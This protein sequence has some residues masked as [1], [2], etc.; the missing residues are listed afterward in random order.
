MKKHTLRYYLCILYSL[1]W[2]PN[3]VLAGSHF[4]S[5]TEIQQAIDEANQAYQNYQDCISNCES[6]REQYI[7]NLRGLIYDQEASHVM[8]DEQFDAISAIPR[9][10]TGKAIMIG[11]SEGNDNI[12]F[13][14]NNVTI[15]APRSRFLWDSM[16]SGQ[17]RLDIGSNRGESDIYQSD[18]LTNNFIELDLPE[19]GRK[20]YLRLSTQVD[21]EWQYNDYMYTAYHRQ[22]D[23]LALHSYTRDDTVPYG[24]NVVFND[25]VHGFNVGLKIINSQGKGRLFF[26]IQLDKPI[27]NLVF[28][29]SATK[30]ADI[31]GIRF[32]SNNEKILFLLGTK[33]GAVAAEGE[34]WHYSSA[35]DKEGI[36]KVAFKI[37]GNG[38]AQVFINDTFAQK[39]TLTEQQK[40]ATYTELQIN[41]IDSIY[42]GLYSLKIENTQ[43]STNCTDS[44]NT[45]SNSNCQPQTLDA[46]ALFELSKSYEQQGLYAKALETIQQALKL[47][48]SNDA[49]WGYAAHYARYAGQDEIGLRYGIQAIERNNQV[50]WYHVTTALSAYN[51]NQ[52]DTAKRYTDS[53]LAFGKESL[54]QTNYDA[55]M[56]ILPELTED[57]AETSDVNP[58]TSSLTNTGKQ[59][60]CLATYQLSGQLHVPCVSVPMGFVDRQLFSIDLQQQNQSASFALDLNTITMVDN[61]IQ[62]DCIASYV[63]NNQLIV[64]CVEADLGTGQTEIYQVSFLQHPDHFIFNVSDIA[65]KSSSNDTPTIN[66][67]R[68]SIE[69]QWLKPCGLAKDGDFYDVVAVSFDSGI[70]SSDIKNY[71]DKNCTL[72]L[73]YSPN[74]TA[75]GRYTLGEFKTTQQAYQAQIIT[76]HIE[77]FNGAPFSI[78]KMDIFYIENEQLYFG[79]KAGLA[80][81]DIPDSLAFERTFY[82]Q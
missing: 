63:N 38:V 47:N 66:T 75:K 76:T 60:A 81:M 43:P 65:P 31:I 79:V 13:P 80:E 22:S 18:I 29:V 46:S 72:P 57:T 36:N 59:D 37:M 71:T 39:I 3:I 82:R 55:L 51:L 49:Y 16:N 41:Q 20:L 14:D 42:F 44:A 1:L 12:N 15:N 69:G 48:P 62:S 56:H 21:G 35:W 30:D 27:F 2:I 23:L 73:S 58:S 4:S 6:I 45:P 24:K 25:G 32:V 70:F 34:D 54:G 28:E 40:Q 68:A 61:N 74:P 19:D 9:L 26:P 67:P 11:H 77:Q 7:K 50:A 53:A 52:K 10:N 33:Q 78:D 5:T 8:T 17:Y 64:P